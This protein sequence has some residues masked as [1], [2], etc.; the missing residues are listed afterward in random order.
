MNASVHTTQAHQHCG[1][2]SP[3]RAG[4]LVN[5]HIPE[6]DCD[7]HDLRKVCSVRNLPNRGQMHSRSWTIDREADAF[8][9]QGLRASGLRVLRLGLPQARR[10]GL[11]RDAPG[12]QQAGSCR[13]LVRVPLSRQESAVRHR[14]GRQARCDVRGHAGCLSGIP[15]WCDSG[16]LASNCNG[17]L[18]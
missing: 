13:Q 10:V 9:D 6:T 11:L 1:T 15:R 7:K 16:V 5:G 12:G 4:A 8:F 3:R 18:R 17:R 14:P 2:A